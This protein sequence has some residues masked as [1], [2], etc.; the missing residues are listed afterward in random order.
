MMYFTSL[1]LSLT[2][3][4]LIY[5][6]TL[7]IIIEH[8]NTNDYAPFSIMTA[9]APPVAPGAALTTSPELPEL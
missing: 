2:K 8:I 4:Y 1:K 6:P 3:V 5:H 7:S 9:P